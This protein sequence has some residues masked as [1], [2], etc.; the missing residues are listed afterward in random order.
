MAIP[1]AKSGE[2]IDIHSLGLALTHAWS[3][4]LVKT[5]PWKSFA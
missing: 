2:V 1:H 5:K 4:T 3:T